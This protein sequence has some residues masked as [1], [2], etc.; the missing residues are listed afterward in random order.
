MRVKF[1]K[2]NDGRI[3]L[4]YNGLSH[5]CNVQYFIYDFPKHRK[6]LEN[7]LTFII[8]FMTDRKIYSSI[9]VKMCIKMTFLTHL[10]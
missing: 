7:N 10:Q 5:V 1:A 3:V 9:G 2:R 6:L 4:S 8:L